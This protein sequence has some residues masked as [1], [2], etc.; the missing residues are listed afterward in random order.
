[1]TGQ[2]VFVVFGQSHF[3]HFVVF[4]GTKE[5]AHGGVFVAELFVAVVIIHVHL[6]LTQILVGNFPR[7]NFD[8]HKAPQQAVVKHQVGKKLIIFEQQAFL[9]GNKRKAVAQFE[10]KLL[11]MADQ[12]RFQFLFVVMGF[13]LQS[14]ELEYHRVFD[15]F[16][17]QLRGSLIPGNSHNGILIIAQ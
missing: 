2:D 7:F 16:L 1:L 5:N 4:A 3:Y 15:D 8:D 10:Q 13:S 6:Q 17:R 12:C 11:Q 9:P 14:Q